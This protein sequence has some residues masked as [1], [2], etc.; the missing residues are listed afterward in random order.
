MDLFLVWL[1]CGFALVVAELVTG[2]FYLL[3]LGI[4]AFAGGAVAWVGGAFPAQAVV[5]GTGAVIGTL[6]VHHYRR[7]RPAARMRGIDVGQPAVFERWIDQASGHARVKYRD[8]SWEA[9]VA[10]DAAAGEVLYVS[11][12]DGNTLKVSKSRPG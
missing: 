6:A 3:V 12:V 9:V 7:G 4:A 8:A 11:G 2:T 1:V 10:G 5:A